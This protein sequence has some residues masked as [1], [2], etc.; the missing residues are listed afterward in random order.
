MQIKK[1]RKFGT[2]NSAAS[3]G[4]IQSEDDPCLYV[5]N[6]KGDMI[7]LI[8]YIYDFLI[9]AKDINKINRI[10]DYLKGHFELTNLGE[11]KHYL[12]IEIRR[13]QDGFFLLKQS[14]YID[15]ILCKFG[16]DDAKVS[17]IPLDQE[18]VKIRSE[19]PLMPSNEKYQQLIGALLYL[20]VNTR[21]DISA[22]VTILSQHNKQP[23]IMDWK[24]AKRVTR[25]LKRTK[26]YE[27]RLGQWNGP[28][29]L[30]GFADAD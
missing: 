25:Y 21:P 7:Y 11:I 23:T 28:Q 5:K 24:E 27:L 13:D 15:K 3:N 29:G 12:R 6:D 22:S 20:A 1:E 26:F 8:V 19:E 18:Y 2:I 16:L 14:K 10:A 9:A 30:I 4:F 17:S